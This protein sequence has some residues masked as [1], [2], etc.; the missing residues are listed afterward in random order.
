MVRKQLAARGI[1]DTAVLTA[2]M[3]IPRHLFV[4]PSHISEAYADRALPIH[5]GQT[6][7]QPFIVAYMLQALQ[8]KTTDRVLEIGTGSGYAAALLLSLIHISKDS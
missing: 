1:R 4:P 2:M 6:I 7:S 3:H 5:A 8:L